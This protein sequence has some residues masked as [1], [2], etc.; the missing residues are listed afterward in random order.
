[1]VG[2]LTSLGSLGP[3]VEVLVVGD[4]NFSYSRAFLRANSTR[5]GAAEINVTATSLDTESQLLEMYPKS[6]KILEELR[7]GGVH[8]RHGVNATKLETC[9][10]DADSA[11]RFDRIVF[12]FPHYA[13]DGGVGNKN[14]RNKIHRHRQL[15]VDFFASASQVLA[16]DGQIWVTLCAGQGGTK[17]ERKNRAVGDTWQIVHCAAVAG[18]VLQD[19]H[20]CPVDALAQLGYYSVGYQSREK[21]FWTED[22]ITHVFRREAPDHKACFPI[23]WTRD[24]SFWVTDEELFTEELLHDVVCDQFPPDT[25]AVSISLLDEYRCEKSGRKSVTYRLDISSSSLALSRDRVNSLAQA[26]LTAIEGSSFGASRA[27]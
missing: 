13:A 2:D 1:M 3:G 17:L 8:V 18:L 20:F 4:G 6:R 19:A 12:N 14:K 25:M 24:I 15:L 10:F 27:T 5:I 11:V 23:E 16:K 7:S 21:A 26:A 22:G 9:A